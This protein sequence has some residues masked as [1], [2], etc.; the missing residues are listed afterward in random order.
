L[1]FLWS[2]SLHQGKESDNKKACLS[3]GMQKRTGKWKA[4]LI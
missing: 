1:I 3:T 2:L 4:L